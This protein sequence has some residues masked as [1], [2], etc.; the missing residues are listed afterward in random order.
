MPGPTASRRLLALIALVVVGALAGA[1]A[2][3]VAAGSKV[4]ATLS[5]KNELGQGAA[6]GKGTF[7]GTFSGTRFCYKLSFSGL[8]QPM[9]AHIHKGT[10]KQNGNIVLDLQP[11]FKNGKA[12]RCVTAKSSLAAAIRRTPSGYYANVHT[13]KYPDGAIRGQLR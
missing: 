8:D 2:N 3:A 11:T 5:G 7:T 4:S 13:K 9:A 12:S 10:A 6:N 1:G